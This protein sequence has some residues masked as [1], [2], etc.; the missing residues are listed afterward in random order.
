V[1]SSLSEDHTLKIQLV[2][3]GVLGTFQQLKN[4]FFHGYELGIQVIV[5][6]LETPEHFLIQNPTTL[7]GTTTNYLCQTTQVDQYS[8]LLEM[9][10]LLQFHEMKMYF[11]SSLFAKGVQIQDIRQP[12]EQ[13][14]NYLTLNREVKEISDLVAGCG[15][16]CRFEMSFEE[17]CL[18]VLRECNPGDGQSQKILKLMKMVG[19]ERKF[20]LD[21][22]LVMLPACEAKSC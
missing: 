20:D 6:L 16:P 14:K 9:C 4:I 1:P 18:T 2:Q 5:N 15:L 21:F 7:K 12:S 11:M 13:I 3:Q 10:D 22:D 8:P 17:R 19:V